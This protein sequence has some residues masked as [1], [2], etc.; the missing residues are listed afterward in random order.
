MPFNQ[1]EID[2]IR[3][4]GRKVAEFAAGKEN[5]LNIQRWKDVNALRK[6]DRAPVWCRPMSCWGE[7]ITPDKYVCKD[8]YLHSIEARLRKVLFKREVNDDE[9][10]DNTFFVET[11]FDIDP[12]NKYGVD[13]A[14]HH[15][16]DTGGA[17]SYEPPLKTPKEFEKLRLPIFTYNKTR[18]EEEMSRVHEILGD[19]LPVRRICLPPGDATICTPATALRGTTEL[20]LDTIAEPELLHRLMAYL[21]DWTLSAMKQVED[22]GLLTSFDTKPTF[23]SDPVGPEPVNGK[24]TYKNLWCHANS[25]GFDQVSPEGWKEFELDYQMPIMDK[26]GYVSYGCCENLTHKIDGVLSI[27]NLRLV[28]CSAWTNLDVIIE[29]CAAKYAIMW[30]QKA[31]DVV[32]PKEDSVIK[33]ALFDGARR[34]QGCKY[35]IVLRELETLA[36][37]L[38]RLHVW[39]RYAKE[40]AEKYR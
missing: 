20:L 25:Q 37:H 11:I 1:K 27:P 19:V 29:K 4:L 10:V 17:W 18:T 38:D 22:A 28:T 31:T 16:G 12:K 26:F 35:Q 21:R 34:L 32:F 9:P 7:L 8:P 3:E 5:K 40:A 36:G 15:S 14:K 39:T 2:T 30:R 13:I 23:I 33:I 6:P 24:V